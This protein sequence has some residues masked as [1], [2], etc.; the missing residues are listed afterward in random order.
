[1]DALV[2]VLLKVSE[3]A[4]EL[5]CIEE[6]DI[7]PVLADETGVIALDAR[8]VLGSG[9]LAADARY[10]HLAIHP[11]PKD[12]WRAVRLRTADTVLLRPIRPEDAEAEQRFVA[13]VSARSMYLRFHAPLRELSLER[14]VRFT[15]IDYDREMAFVAIDMQGDAEEIHGIARYT[16]NPDGLSCEFGILVEDTWHG[17]GLGAALMTALESCARERGLQEMV[18]IVLAENDDMARLMTGRGFEP[19]RDPDDA[20]VFRFV[21]MLQAGPAG[22][23]ADRIG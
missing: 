17:R 5:P 12:L 22:A 23:A 19:Q 21:K 4:C 2:D 7:N 14:L 11:Y 20:H 15:Q 8:V 1:M 10:S 3:L 9:A 18:G 13:R 16:R 6:L